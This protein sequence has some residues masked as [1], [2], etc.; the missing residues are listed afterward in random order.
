MWMAMILDNTNKD[1]FVVTLITFASKKKNQHSFRIQIPKLTCLY[2]IQQIQYKHQHFL[3][4]DLDSYYHR[5]AFNTITYHRKQNNAVKLKVILDCAV[6]ISCYSKFWR[7]LICMYTALITLN[8]EERK[9]YTKFLVR[10]QLCAYFRKLFIEPFTFPH[11]I[12]SILFKLWATF[13]LNRHIKQCHHSHNMPT[14]EYC[15]PCLALLH[16]RSPERGCWRS[17]V[18]FNESSRKLTFNSGREYAIFSTDHFCTPGITFLST[19][20]HYLNDIQILYKLHV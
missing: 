16:G 18:P 2:S 20:L 15:F 10:N 11:C 7:V 8:K 9:Y 19:A 17:C 3:H 12:Y 5:K 14:L 1:A 4:L 6:Y 13:L